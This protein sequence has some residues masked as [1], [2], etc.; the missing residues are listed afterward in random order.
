LDLSSY[1]GGNYY[2][3]PFTKITN[4][5]FSSLTTF[6]IDKDGV[7]W[8]S[9]QLENVAMVSLELSPN[10]AITNFVLKNCTILI[11]RKN[12]GTLPNAVFK[13][14]GSTISGDPLI[15]KTLEIHN[16]NILNAIGN[17][18]ASATATGIVEGSVITGIIGFSASS[19]FN[20]IFKNNVLRDNGRLAFY[21]FGAN[22]SF[23]STIIANNSV[24][25]GPR[26]F[27]VNSVSSWNVANIGSYE[28][29]GNT[30]ILKGEDKIKL[31]LRIP[32]YTYGATIPDGTLRY[33]QQRSANSNYC[34]L[35]GV[36]I[37][38]LLFSFG[39][40]TQHDILAETEPKYNTTLTEPEYLREFSDS[41]TFVN[42]DTYKN[43]GGAICTAIYDAGVVD[44]KG[45]F[46]GTFGGYDC[47]DITHSGMSDGDLCDIV[48]NVE[49]IYRAEATG[50]L[51]K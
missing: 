16:C 4:A 11:N 23:V 37:G 36:T 12:S 42:S 20:V 19:T 47:L 18:A 38:D 33:I 39:E 31:V 43:V 6:P 17:D 51:V 7:K 15:V 30:G 9:L 48:L 34:D 21:G 26:D 32:Y 40:N 25:D 50:G 49:K 3:F 13:A 35:V 41:G 45:V 22:Q 2:P 29:K 8:T 44:T 46:D 24:E 27:I 5:T 14:Q 1:G 10:T 28:Y